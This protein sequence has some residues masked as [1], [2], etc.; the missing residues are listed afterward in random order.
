MPIVLRLVIL[1][2][3]LERKRVMNTSESYKKD[4]AKAMNILLDLSYND[5]VSEN[6]KKMAI[7]AYSLLNDNLENI[8]EIRELLFS[9]E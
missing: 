6:D 5:D 9:N 1:V 2:A 3:S 7:T 4:F 8:E